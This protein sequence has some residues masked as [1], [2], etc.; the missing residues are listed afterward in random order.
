MHLHFMSFHIYKA[1]INYSYIPSIDLMAS[2]APAYVKK[3]L[4]IV[5]GCRPI[6]GLWSFLWILWISVG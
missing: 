2:L 5:G 6:A 3:A 4:A 1:I